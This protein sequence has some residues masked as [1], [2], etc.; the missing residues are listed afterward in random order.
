MPDLSGF[1]A[2]DVAIGLFFLY[3]LLSTVLSSINEAIA[4]LLGWRAN[5]LEDAIRSLVADPKVKRGWKEWVGRVDTRGLETGSTVQSERD[6]VKVEADLTSAVLDHWRIRA[7]VRDPR[8]PVRRRS[9]PS[10]L[11]PRALSLAIAETLAQGAPDSPKGPTLWQ[12]AD[13]SI[14]DQATAV[15][16]KLPQGQ[17]REVLQKAAAN[18]EGSWRD[19]GLRSSVPSTT[20]WNAPRAGTS[21]RSS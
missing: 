5:T 17:T 2:L 1:P 18:A 9:R 16:D 10:Y 19:S 15:L 11:P 12:R 20:P 3:F 6:G 8:S 13:Q 4:N 14:L 7:L 21:A